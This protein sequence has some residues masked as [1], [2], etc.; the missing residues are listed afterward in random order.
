M[1]HHFPGVRDGWARF[2]G[3]AGTQMVDVAVNAMTDWAANGSNANTGGYF[4]AANKCDALL[5]STRSVLGEFLG[6]D[7]SVL[8]AALARPISP[9][10]FFDRHPTVKKIQNTK[11]KQKIYKNIQQ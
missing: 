1:R 2:D 7:S 4:D 3:P 8:R 5:D 10:A 6:A 11:Q 9:E